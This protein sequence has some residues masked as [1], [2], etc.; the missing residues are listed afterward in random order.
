MSFQKDL[1]DVFHEVIAH[2]IFF[3]PTYELRR[4][5]LAKQLTQQILEKVAAP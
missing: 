5:I 1:V 3:N 4:D 2:R